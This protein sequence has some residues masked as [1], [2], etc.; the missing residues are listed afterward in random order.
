VNPK[1]A[2]LK[3]RTNKENYLLLGQVTIQ[4]ISKS[5]NKVDKNV[6]QT[7]MKMSLIM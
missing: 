5:C 2:L 6:S 7:R 3:R 4:A 1:V